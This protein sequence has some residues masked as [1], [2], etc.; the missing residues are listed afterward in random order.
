MSA[1]PNLDKVIA[2]LTGRNSQELEAR[3]LAAIDKLCASSKDGFAIR[4][5]PKV[6][7]IL[8]IT[9]QLL[10]K[11]NARFLQPAI[12]TANKPFVRLTATDEFRLLGNIT[13]M[14]SSIGQ[15]FQP[16]IPIDLQIAASEM[17]FVFATGY[18]N[19]PSM[20]DKLPAVQELDTASGLRQYLSN[21]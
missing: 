13:S 14:L 11:G 15:L 5:L 8:E 20:L 1:A 21:Q 16:Q 12:S 6:Q 3:H 2:L 19:R 4:D 9:V 18:G 17:L 10:L 7:Q